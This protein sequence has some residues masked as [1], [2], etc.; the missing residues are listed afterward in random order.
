MG[1]KGEDR[2]VGKMLAIRQICQT[3]PGALYGKPFEHPFVLII[4][5]WNVEM[6]IVLALMYALIATYYLFI[7]GCYE[8]NSVFHSK[9]FR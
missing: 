2:L 5:P 7:D 4:E 9:C 8:Q 3:F 6:Y 1:F